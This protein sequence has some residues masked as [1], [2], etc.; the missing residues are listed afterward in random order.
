MDTASTNMAP[1]LAKTNGRFYNI[2]RSSLFRLEEDKK[3]IQGVSQK[4]LDRG[5]IIILSWPQLQVS[6]VPCKWVSFRAY[7]PVTTLIPL[8]WAT[9]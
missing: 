3:Q 1:V 4:F 9:L 2:L 6:I 8:L 7:T 5:N